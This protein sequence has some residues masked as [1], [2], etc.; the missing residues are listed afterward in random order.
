VVDSARFESVP[1]PDGD[2]DLTAM[3]VLSVSHAGE[4]LVGREPG[5]LGPWAHGVPPMP[6]RD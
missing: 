2:V 4:P 6:L 5:R 3:L 1:G